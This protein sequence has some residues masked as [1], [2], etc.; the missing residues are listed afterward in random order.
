[1]DVIFNIITLNGQVYVKREQDIFLEE[2]KHMI[3]LLEEQSS[4]HTTEIYKIDISKNV[5]HGIYF[6][7]SN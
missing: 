4:T 3:D 5:L 2:K 6:K 7:I 1:M